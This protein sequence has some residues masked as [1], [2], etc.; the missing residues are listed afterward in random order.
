MTRFSRFSRNPADSGA[1]L[2]L[3]L[4]VV[5]VIGLTG[6]AMLSFADTSVRVT[7]RLSEQGKGV[8]GA[9]AAA[10][11]AINALRK[12]A[13]NNDP[14]SGTYPMC[15]GTTSELDMTASSYPG[16]PARV[17]CTPYP[18]TGASGSAVPISAANKPGYA[19]LTLG[20]TMSSTQ[21]E[22]QNYDHK[23]IQIHGGVVSNS[24]ISANNLT[25]TGGASALAVNT[26]CNV[27]SPTCTKLATPVADPNYPAPTD[28]VKPPTTAPS[29]CSKKNAV[30]EFWPGLYND[31]SVLNNCVSNVIWFHPGTYYFDFTVGTARVWDVATTVVGGTPTT[32]LTSTPPTLPGSCVNPINSATAQGVE[33]AFGGTSQVKLDKNANFEICATYQASTPPTAIYGLK[34]DVTNGGTATAHAQTGCIRLVVTAGGCAMVTSSNGDKPVFYVQGFA[35]APFASMNLQLNNTSQQIFNFGIVLRGIYVDINPQ[36][37][38]QTVISIPDN[39]PG[40]GI[41]QTIVDLDVYVC[42]GASTCTTTSPSAK[43]K[44]R[45][46]VLIK[47]PTGSPL[48]GKR[49]ITVL[50]WSMQR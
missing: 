31:V 32:T 1:A 15:F 19:V 38:G 45:A 24:D 27:V 33:F 39:S 49:E 46:R 41:A 10:Q 28:P 16:A 17:R 34:T 35:Y 48:S 6:S 50:S 14:A 5:T 25:V 29:N 3:V 11:M 20:S 23:P 13:F 30:A 42:V 37:Q 9:D 8:Y 40:Y 36:I 2:I 22:G 7:I 47:D 4:I 21:G 26:P 12:G 43:L 18:G 44:L